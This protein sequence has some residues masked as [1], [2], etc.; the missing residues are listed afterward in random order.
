MIPQGSHPKHNRFSLRRKYSTQTP[1]LLHWKLGMYPIP[2]S[3]LR[4]LSCGARVIPAVISLSVGNTRTQRSRWTK[5]KPTGK[6]RCG[7]Y[8]TFPNLSQGPHLL[9]SAFRFEI[10]TMKISSNYPFRL[11]I[12]INPNFQASL[13]THIP[14]PS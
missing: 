9:D 11:K 10:R 12:R 5:Q 13:K 7:D 8:C 1:T 14:L 6:Y 3:P 2:I 4:P